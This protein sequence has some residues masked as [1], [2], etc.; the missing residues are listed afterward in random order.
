MQEVEDR[1][2]RTAA[3]RGRILNLALILILGM[4][5]AALDQR[6]PFRSHTWL[7][8]LGAGLTAILGGFFFSW[9]RRRGRGGP[10]DD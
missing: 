3:M 10:A 8:V 6:E 7:T 5:W 9:L 2:A 1:A 4:L